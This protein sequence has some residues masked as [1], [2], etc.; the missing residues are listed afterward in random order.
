MP[1]HYEVLGIHRS[2]TPAE[3][4]GA[5]QVLVRELHPDRHGGTP[6]ANA[7]F[8]LVTC[9]YGVLREEKSRIAYDRRLRVLGENCGPCSGSGRTGKSQGFSKT[10]WSICA[11]CRGSGVKE[12]K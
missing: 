4:R 7:A 9:A 11:A 2:S 3:T 5:Y 6:E 1:H 8:A 10:V 12:R